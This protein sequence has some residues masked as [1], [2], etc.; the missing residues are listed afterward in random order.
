MPAWV[1]PLLLV[2]EGEQELP[3]SNTLPGRSVPGQRLPGGCKASCCARGCPQHPSA[4]L[5]LLHRGFPD[6][7]PAGVWVQPFLPQPDKPWK[8][9]SFLCRTGWVQEQPCPLPTH[10][11]SPAWPTPSPCPNSPPFFSLCSLSQIKAASP[12]P[13]ITNIIQLLDKKLSSSS[14]L[15]PL[16][17]ERRQREKDSAWPG[18]RLMFHATP[19]QKR[20][21]SFSQKVPW[22]AWVIINNYR[23]LN[24]PSLSLS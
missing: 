9:T 24:P 1:Q 3:G 8:P 2:R 17:A 7:L 5:P 22:E 12:P 18:L 6:F 4:V 11:H 16:E 15:I 13:R 19:L 21:T 23:T 20:G 10:Q 14:L